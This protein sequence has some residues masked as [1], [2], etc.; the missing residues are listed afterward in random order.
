MP[1]PVASFEDS[2]NGRRV[3][4]LLRAVTVRNRDSMTPRVVRC[5]MAGCWTVRVCNPLAR[6]GR[7]L[8]KPLIRNDLHVLREF[9]NPALC[10]ACAGFDDLFRPRGLGYG[11]VADRDSDVVDDPGLLADVAP[12]VAER[13][14]VELG[15]AE[16]QETVAVAR[17]V[18]HQLAALIDRL[19]YA[20][21]GP[22]AQCV[23]PVAPENGVLGGFG[24]FGEHAEALWI[25]SLHDA[26]VL[27]R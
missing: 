14:L 9:D 4:A 3:W 7:N 19:G 21:N 12:V 17:T 8:R 13:R 11:V 5:P 16:L 1:P 10:R 25:A 22:L 15:Q 6:I 20:L 24:G 2:A 26:D 23:A 27:P 18:P